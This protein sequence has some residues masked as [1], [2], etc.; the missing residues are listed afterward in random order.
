MRQL[1][2]AVLLGL[3][4]VC[5]SAA[6]V[7]QADRDALEAAKESGSRRKVIEAARVLALSAIAH[8]E[9]PEAGRIAYDTGWLLCLNFSCSDAVKPGRFA[10]GRADAPPDAAV[11]APFADYRVKASKKNARALD[12]ALRTVESGAPTG[13]TLSAFRELYSQAQLIRDFKGM[14]DWWGRGPGRRPPGGGGAGAET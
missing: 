2:I 1:L 5:G 12:A 10:A 13:L 8:P 7:P 9:D 14:A 4:A 3:I 6:Q 11:L